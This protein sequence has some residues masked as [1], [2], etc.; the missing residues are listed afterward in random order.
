M[1]KRHFAIL[2]LIITSGIWGIAVPV[3]KYTLQFTTPFTF[4]FFRLLIA[5]LIVFPFFVQDMKKRTFEK[6]DVLKLILLSLFGQTFHLSFIFMGLDR[7]TALEGS[8]IASIIPVFTVIAGAFI[9]KETIMSLEKIGLAII[10][11]GTLITFSDSISAFEHGSSASLLGNAL[12]IV[13]GLSWTAFAILSKELF[14]KYSPLPITAFTFFIGLLTFLP[15]MLWEQV[16]MGAN[17]SL[18]LFLA[19]P[20]I[21]Y[22]GIF[23]SVVAYGL[24]ELGLE[25]VEASEADIFAYI[26]PLFAFPASYLILRETPTTILLI[27]MGIIAMGVLIYNKGSSDQRKLWRRGKI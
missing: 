8:V 18:N 12:L 1:N 24:Y 3:I 16:M 11:A 13:G 14:E 21:L 23:S 4:I 25:Y 22:M 17:D 19:A 10:L 2:S 20:G 26:V 9:L 27:G 15:L 7:T 5:S 6:R